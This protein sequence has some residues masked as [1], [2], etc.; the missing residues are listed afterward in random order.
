MLWLGRRGAEAPATS[1]MCCTLGSEKEYFADHLHAK[2]S[3]TGC[4][5]SDTGAA[6]GD[7]GLRLEHL[8]CE[9][10]TDGGSCC[11]RSR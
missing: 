6:H 7:G 4:G 5:L 2:D 3:E 8:V 11:D 9:T 1:G 10:D